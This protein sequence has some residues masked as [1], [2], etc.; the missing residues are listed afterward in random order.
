M[1][2]SQVLRLVTEQPRQQVG[3][4]AFLP[5][6]DI[7]RMNRRDVHGVVV[8]TGRRVKKLL[9]ML[10]IAVRKD[11]SGPLHKSP[12]GALVWKPQALPQIVLI[13]VHGLV[14]GLIDHSTDLNRTE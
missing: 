10:T 1:S 5:L 3:R 2:G 4:L 9:I 14:G 12:K 6:I 13:V 11:L 7:I 8:P